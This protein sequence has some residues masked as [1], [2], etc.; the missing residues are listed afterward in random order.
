MTAHSA[1]R[2]LFAS[3]R[4]SKEQCKKA[5]KV[6]DEKGTNVITEREAR[7]IKANPM[8]YYNKHVEK[9]KA[10]APPAKPPVKTS[11]SKK[12]KK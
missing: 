2:A 1:I 9:A 10:P 7:E 6:I 8:V 5:F 4:L 3:G 11:G 12:Q